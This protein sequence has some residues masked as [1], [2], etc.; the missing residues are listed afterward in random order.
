MSLTIQD[1]ARRGIPLTDLH[2]IDA[3]AHLGRCP[4]IHAA[5]GDAEG[6]IASMDR[7]GIQTTCLSS[8]QALG[9][10]YHQGNDRVADAVKRYPSRLL[11]YVTLNPNY[12]DDI[13]R[14]L[15]RGLDE[16]GCFAVKLHPTWH[17]YPPDGPAYHRVFAEMQARR[18]VVLSHTFGGPTTLESLASRYPNVTFIVAHVAAVYDAK[19]AE[20][21][22]VV[23]D[24]R[25]NIYLDMAL[26]VARYGD[27]ERWVEAVGAGRLLFGSD[28]PFN[29][30]AHQVGRVTHAAIS[31][32]D[33]R[34]ILG[35][36][37]AEIVRDAL[38]PSS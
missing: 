10:D 28:V 2:I 17:E 9:G 16:L 21:L 6:I 38:Q 4:I 26:S 11:G 18:G 22:A 37:M 30:N 35:G 1:R 5:Y 31:A 33:K 15:R 29:D 14:E 25:P 12:P 27:L 3:H 13:E 19:L 7:I 20:A 36:T 32:A 23:M 8:F 24:N 34:A